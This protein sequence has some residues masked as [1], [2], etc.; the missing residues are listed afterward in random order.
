MNCEHC[1]TDFVFES[2]YRPVICPF[3]G[4][5]TKG[6]NKPSFHETWAQIK[7]DPILR[8]PGNIRQDSLLKVLQ[9]YDLA[10]KEDPEAFYGAEQFLKTLA[11]NRRLAQG[12]ISCSHTLAQT[13]AL[14]SSEEEQVLNYRLNRAMQDPGV[15]LNTLNTVL[16]SQA[17]E[18]KKQK[19]MA[20]LR[21]QAASLSADLSAYPG[22]QHF[23]DQ[24]ASVREWRKAVTGLEET[25]F[26]IRDPDWMGEILHIS[27]DVQGR[28]SDLEKALSKAEPDAQET[29]SVFFRPLKDPDHA[30]D[31]QSLLAEKT[32]DW[33]SENQEAF[34]A[35]CRSLID[36]KS[37]LRG[38]H[39]GLT[40]LKNTDASLQEWIDPLL[41]KQYEAVFRQ[42]YEWMESTDWKI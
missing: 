8:G 24:A 37:V 10:M 38:L 39:L 25:P 36:E 5:K 4:R 16:H 6:S 1:K 29:A 42:P 31:H 12:L 28:E 27:M 14:L 34:S 11:Q 33:A 32:A 7:A 21:N 15:L 13:A 40:L 26:E 35:A 23:G 3:C 17:D 30:F 20:E 19:A 18:E 9:E 22:L 2:E 41:E